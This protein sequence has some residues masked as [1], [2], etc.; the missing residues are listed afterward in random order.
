MKGLSAIILLFAMCIGL[1]GA[2]AQGI[3]CTTC[4]PTQ[5]LVGPHAAAETSCT[6]CHGDGATHVTNPASGGV[7]TFED[8]PVEARSAACQTCHSDVHPQDRS[9]HQR[10]GV[11]CNDCHTIHTEPAES[12]SSSL[13]HAFDD[14]S[15]WSHR[16][17][18]AD[19]RLT[20][21]SARLR[22]ALG[23]SFVDIARDYRRLV[24]GGGRQ[25]LFDV[26]YRGD[27]RLLDGLVEYRFENALSVGGS[28]QSYRNK[29][30]FAVDHRQAAVFL[31]YPLPQNYRLEASYRNLDYDEDLE[32]Y[33]A[34]IVELAIG[35]DW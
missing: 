1:N 23:S 3:A 9:A 35:I 14:N 15:D 2:H 30:S 21:D 25:D 5:T 13:G 20:Y 4:H 12:P 11:G 18:H 6:S 22:F 19:L 7:T 10:A 34:D 16:R 28:Y 31:R 26:D 17:E 8:E 33:D 32:D 29:G 27:T 24:T